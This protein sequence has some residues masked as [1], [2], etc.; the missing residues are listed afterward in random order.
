MAEAATLLRGCAMVIA[1]YW[2]R[3]RLTS[4]PRAT[5]KAR[6]KRSLPCGSGNKYKRSCETPEQARRGLRRM[7]THIRLSGDN[8]RAAGPATLR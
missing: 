4:E 3:C 7:A 2:R 1:D 5:R 6:P 8:L